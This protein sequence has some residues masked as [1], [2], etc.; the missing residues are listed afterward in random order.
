MADIAVIM[1]Q[2]IPV[3][4]AMELEDIG[5]WHGLAIDRYNRMNG[6]E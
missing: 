6:G 1:N 2:P 3:L 4:E 5:H